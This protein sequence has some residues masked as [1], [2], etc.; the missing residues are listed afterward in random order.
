MKSDRAFFGPGGNSRAFYD[1]GYKSTVDAPGWVSSIGLDAYEYEAGS[2]L[3]ASAGTLLLI[4]NKARDAG[5]RMSLH[6]PYFI[7]LSGVE[8]VK[9]LG[10]LRY[11]SQSLSAAKLLGAYLIVV[12]TG[13]AAKISR[14]EA[15]RLAADTLY[16]LLDEI[17]D[18]GVLIGLETMG[19]INQLG[20]LEE[21]IEQ[22]CVDRHYVPVVDFGH[23]NA[24]NGGNAF[25]TADHYRAIFDRIGETLGDEIAR[26]LHC[27]FSKIEYT[28]AGEKRHVTFEDTVYGPSFEPLME[29]IVKEDLSPRIICESAGTMPEDALTMK[30]YYLSLKDNA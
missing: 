23:L 14:A 7:S 28:A 25:P 13:S 29:A 5:I 21:V 24:R 17:P 26:N 27:H 20:T 3:T 18:N 19:K 16:H 4:G 8:E 11:I 1:A 30:Q 12:H 15:M 10:S 6:A 2:G 9:R 22:C